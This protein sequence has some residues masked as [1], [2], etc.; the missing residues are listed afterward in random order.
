MMETI[1]RV[2]S[3]RI[4]ANSLLGILSLVTVFHLFVLM[5]IIPFE[6]VW[7]GRLESTDQMIVFESVSLLVN[8]IMIL[9]VMLHKGHF[10][11]RADQRITTV[12]LWFMTILFL[13]NTVGNLLSTNQTEKI[14][15]TPLTAILCVFCF[16]LAIGRKTAVPT[17]ESKS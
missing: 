14:I 17:V 11:V 12:V 15:F 13:I 10:K 6:I 1:R 9:V 3:E 5:G 4:A 2:I 8:I 7:G 16:R